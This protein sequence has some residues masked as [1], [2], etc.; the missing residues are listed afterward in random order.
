M[1]LNGI[2]E[3]YIVVSISGEVEKPVY[4]YEFSANETSDLDQATSYDTQEESEQSADLLNQMA[5]LQQT[6]EMFEARKVTT[7]IEGVE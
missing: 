4:V 1:S 5:E 3:K 6:G 2:T 7:I